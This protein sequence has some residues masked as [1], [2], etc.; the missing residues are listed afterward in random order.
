MR[1][2]TPVFLALFL[3]GCVSLDP[4]WQRPAPPVPAVWPGA[5]GQA[6]PNPAAAELAGWKR[7]IADPRLQTLVGQALHSNRD[8]QKALADIAAARA[9]Y[10]EQRGSLFPALDADLSLTRSRTLAYG[11]S[12][13]AEAQGAVSS[14][15]V[16]LFGRN[17]SLTRA[18]RE[19]WLASEYTALSTRLTLIADTTTAWLT[20]AADNSNLA[21]AKNTLQSA[22]DSLA[23]TLRRQ[24]A[25]VAASSDVAQAKTVYQ[26]A[27]ASV[28]SYQTLV[29]QDK[30]ALDLL[31]G[32]SVPASLL[33]GLLESLTDDSIVLVPAGVSSSVLLRRPDVQ[34]A[35]HNLK[36]AN[37]NIGA[38]RA[39]FFPSITLTA[40]AGVGSNSLANL[41]SHGSRIWAFSPSVTLPLF[42]GGSNLAQLRYAQAQQQ[43][44][45]AS[46]EKTIQAAFR[47]VADALAR[48]GTLNEQLDAQRNYVAAAQQALD[49]A[50]RLYRAGSADYLSVLTARRSLWS[51]QEQLIT[52]Q[53]TDLENR[54]T[55]WQ[56]LGGGFS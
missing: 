30:N 24:Q 34:E 26:Q 45:I 5:S 32:A 18:A 52:L 31:V 11:V 12:E 20:L 54:I 9:L 48:R 21:L 4:A 6:S 43:G 39:S 2:F 17:Q 23:V 55:L 44:L 37:A 51:A 53:Q 27:R 14:F 1:R 10:A 7:V 8:L 28:A 50:E 33:P 56:S 15:E 40:S 13:S 29:M 36:S 3:A 38:A 35:E 22:A 47:D 42:A 25:G 46:Y 16:D 19:T 41:F 49:S